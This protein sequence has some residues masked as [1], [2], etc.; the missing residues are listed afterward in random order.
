MIEP[1]EW[2]VSPDS[3]HQVRGSLAKTDMRLEHCETEEREKSS[4]GV[5]YKIRH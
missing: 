2:V 5:R 3:Q 1:G 4:R